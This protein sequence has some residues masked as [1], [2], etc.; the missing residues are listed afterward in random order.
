MKTALF[1]GR[2]QPMH[3]GHLKAIKWILEKYDKV[4]IVI[5]SSQESN[6]DKNPFDVEERKE[7]INKILKT[8]NITNYEIIEI[9]DV[10][11]DEVWVKL[12]LEKASFEIVFTLN[13]WVER[14][15]KEFNIEVKGHP[16]FGD[17]SGTMIRKLVRDGKQWE[18][19]VP[20]EVVEIVKRHEI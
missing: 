10:H 18:D 6:T 4:I 9:P 15:F 3:V 8:E 11:D 17:I 13:S 12:I 5:G 20:K 2:F 1:V 14:C 19:L 7:M 16:M